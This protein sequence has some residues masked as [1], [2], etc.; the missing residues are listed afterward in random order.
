[1][2]SLDTNQ[3]LELIARFPSSMLDLDQAIVDWFNELTCFLSEYPGY[4]GSPV[5][6]YQIWTWSSSL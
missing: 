5:T 3:L 6:A 1:V 2:P 4:H